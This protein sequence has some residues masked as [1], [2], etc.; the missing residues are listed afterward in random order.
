MKFRLDKYYSDLVI[1][2][3]TLC[4]AYLATT[5]LGALRS[6][7]AGAEVFWPDGSRDMIRASGN[8]RTWSIPDWS[9]CHEIRFP[10]DRGEFRLSYANGLPGWHSADQPARELDWLVIKPKAAGELSWP[11][12]NVSMEGVGYVDRVRL[13]RPLSR[14]GFRR[15]EWGRVHAGEA[16]LVFCSLALRDKEPWQRAAWWP[17]DQSEPLI[18]NRFE[19]A[20]DT[21][22]MSVRTVPESADA[23]M[24]IT[25]E[26]LLHRGPVIGVAPAPRV[27]DRALTRLLA[28]RLE[29]DRWIGR[30]RSISGPASETGWAVHEVVSSPDSPKVSRV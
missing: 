9:T 3:G 1:S 4:I 29:D 17:P 13:R 27:R 7:Y 11:G 8:P 10:C 24:R 6:T 16:A 28:G 14:I 26:R 2:D 21:G 30:A 12:S 22:G 5:R 18:F 15:L 19:T 25:A 23:T 20:R